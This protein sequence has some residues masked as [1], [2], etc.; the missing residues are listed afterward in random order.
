V[1]QPESFDCIGC[2][3]TIEHIQD[4]QQLLKKLY[5]LLKPQG[6]LLCSTPNQDKMPFSRTT[7]PFHRRH[8]TPEQFE[9]LLRGAGFAIAEKWSQHNIYAA[10]VSDGWSGFFNIAVCKKAAT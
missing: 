7:H 1:L 10:K 6:T 9:A 2:F 4:D 3:E 8:Y 5:Q